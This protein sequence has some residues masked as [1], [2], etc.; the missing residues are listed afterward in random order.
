M[1][2]RPS[3]SDGLCPKDA[4]TKRR[5]DESQYDYAAH[6]IAAGN[7]LLRVRCKAH[8]VRNLF[9]SGST[10]FEIGRAPI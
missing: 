6:Q 2:P 9:Y 4:P 7:C 10:H 1:P 3:R 8:R 5:Q